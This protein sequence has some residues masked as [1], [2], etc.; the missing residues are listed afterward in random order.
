MEEKRLPFR[1][2]HSAAGSLPSVDDG[3]CSCLEALGRHLCSS[4]RPLK[5]CRTGQ[6]QAVRDLGEAWRVACLCMRPW[7]DYR[8]GYMG[9]KAMRSFDDDDDDDEAPARMSTSAGMRSG[10]CTR[11]L[12]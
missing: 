1:P 9:V 6:G 11:C 12:P 10:S 8:T 5:G 3:E 4:M 7:K 2:R